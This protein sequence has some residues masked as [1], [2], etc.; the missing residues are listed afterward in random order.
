[1]I[2]TSKKATA[3]TECE[4]FYAIRPR[5]ETTRPDRKLRYSSVGAAVLLDAASALSVF[6]YSIFVCLSFKSSGVQCE[7]KMSA[8]PFS[9]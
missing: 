3:F 4:L 1:M 7:V 8:H 9:I 6:K 2:A 5:Y